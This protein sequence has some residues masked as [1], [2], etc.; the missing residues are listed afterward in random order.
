[1]NH[2][3][4]TRREMCKLGTG[5][6]AFPPLA[7]EWLCAAETSGFG[8][9]YV[10]GSCLYGTTRIEEILP[11]VRRTGAEHIDI[12]PLRHG[13]QREQVDAMG[14]DAFA[15]LLARHQVKLGMLTRYDLGPFHLDY[16][17]RVLAKLG[18][19]LLITGAEGP[20]GLAGAELKAAVKQFA[21][22]MK[23]SIAQAKE[24]DVVI[25]IENHGHS[26]IESPDSMKWF[27][28][29]TD[30]SHVGIAM[31]PYHTQ[32]DP[33]VIAGLIH[34]L[35]PGL[36]HFYAWEHGL[37]CF[38]KL[39]K[40]DELKQLPGRG[41]LDFTPIVAALKGIDYAG[42]VEIFMHPVPRGIPILETTEQVT[43]AINRARA[44]L[45]QCLTNA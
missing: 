22:R 2:A 18:G 28:E 23:R 34:D 14:L 3:R 32:Q 10:L 9:R 17:M 36:V 41:S 16:E 42:W 26:L 35:G 13:N 19:R 29:F 6:L 45:A 39:P 15:E 44:Y 31:A 4:Y 5:A 27:V 1:M 24:R 7:S 21:D 20:R 38:E 43:A 25:G 11:E 30:S 37:G 12:W 40:E 33:Q 8:F